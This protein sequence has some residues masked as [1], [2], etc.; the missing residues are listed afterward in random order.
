MDEWKTMKE[1]NEIPKW[2]KLGFHSR[3]AYEEW[4]RELAEDV[5]H[6]YC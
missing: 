6:G 2:K 1:Q 5:R 4:S 3:I